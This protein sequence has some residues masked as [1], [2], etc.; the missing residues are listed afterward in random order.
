MNNINNINTKF[1]NEIS[2]NGYKLDV[3]KSALQ[4]YIRRG[5]LDKSIYVVGSEQ[6]LY[7]QQ[8][9][10]MAELLGNKKAKK[11]YHLPYGLV[12]LPEGK[13]SG[14]K[15]NVV[16]L[17]SMLNELK[18]LAYEKVEKNNP[19]LSAKDKNIIS[20]KI[21]L[22]ALK[23][24]LLKTSPERNVLF[25]KK[26]VIQFEGNTGPYLQYTLTRINSILKKAKKWKPNF[27]NK[28]LTREEKNLIT[29]LIEFPVILEKASKDYRPYYL[30]NYIYDL[31]TIFNEFYH[32][33]PVIKSDQRN[34]R[35]TL[36]KAAGIVIENGLKLL[37]IRIPKKM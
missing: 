2:F 19:K 16:L 30:C 21:A 7:L 4:K 34:F 5:N 35:L 31:S 33:C 32:A 9:F 24:S 3:L 6:K 28:N 1:R 14:R 37:G 18:H 13:M 15:G 17:D 29:K 26:E 8:V 12:M 11:C 20:E 22:G 25:D 36:T 10:K 27:E 23:Y